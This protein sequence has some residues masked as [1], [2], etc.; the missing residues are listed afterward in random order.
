ME[1]FD[2][3]D[4]ENPGK[5][6]RETLICIEKR[7]GVVIT[8]HDCRGL[9]YSKSGEHIFED[10][11]RHTHPFCTALRYSMPFWHTYCNRSCLFEAESLAR[12]AFR[13]HKVDFQEIAHSAGKELLL[14]FLYLDKEIAT[15]ADMEKAMI[16][17]VRLLREKLV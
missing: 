1:Y 17:A 9:L 12:E 5:Y 15:Y 14:A 11:R 16:K 7:F 3:M 6:L 4:P 13:Q 8:I 2:V 10:H